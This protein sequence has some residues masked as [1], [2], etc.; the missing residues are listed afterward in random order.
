MEIMWSNTHS[1]QACWQS[2][3]SRPGLVFTDVSVRISS[4]PLISWPLERMSMICIRLNSICQVMWYPCRETNIRNSPECSELFCKL[5]GVSLTESCREF[6]L[7]WFCGEYVLRYWGIIWNVFPV[8]LQY[9]ADTDAVVSVIFSWVVEYYPA[10]E[11][12]MW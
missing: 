5:D 8:I 3:R 7:F 11:V 2:V 10:L 6:W 12:W 4:I 9:L 1:A